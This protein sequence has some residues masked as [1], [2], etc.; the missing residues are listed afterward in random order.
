MYVYTSTYALV[1]PLLF[2]VLTMQLTFIRQNFRLVDLCN[3]ELLSNY[4]VIENL[5]VNRRDL[6]EC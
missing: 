2:H 6:D 3:Y 5:P 1:L 4:K